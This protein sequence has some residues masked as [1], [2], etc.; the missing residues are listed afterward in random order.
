[1][2]EGEQEILEAEGS[3]FRYSFL[4]QPCEPKPSRRAR[5]ARPMSQ[6]SAN[7]AISRT[8]VPCHASHIFGISQSST[9]KSNLSPS[10]NARYVSGWSFATTD[11]HPQFLMSLKPCAG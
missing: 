5:R 4:V 9:E 2:K 3:W 6:R 7:W 10:H 11:N 8:K 1:V